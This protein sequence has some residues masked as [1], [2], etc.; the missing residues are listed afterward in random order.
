MAGKSLFYLLSKL[1]KDVL[2]E[3]IQSK[4][5][6]GSFCDRG[7][8][9][10]LCVMIFVL[11]ASIALL[12]SFAA[13]AIC[14][15]FLKK[16]HCVVIEWP[17]RTPCLNLLGKIHFIWQ[18]FAPPVNFL[19]RPLQFLTL[20][21][22]ISVLFSQY[23]TL[24]LFAF[25]GKFIKCVFL[26]FSFI[27]AFSD[28][29][30][31]RIF[32]KF[33]L[34]SAFITALNGIIQHYT[35][36][37]YLN[38]HFISV[39]RV[40][41]F[42]NTA[43]GLGAYLLPVIGIVTHFLYSAIVRKKSWVLGGVLAICLV[44]LLACL[45]W[46]YSRS[47]WVGYLVILFVMVLFDRRKM[48]FL[49]VLL[50]VFIFMFL[51]S[52]S[53][54]RHLHLI[55][56]N[57]GMGIQKKDLFQDIESILKQ[58]PVHDVKFILEEGGSGRFNFWMNAAS[59]IR[60]S[61]VWGSGLN[62]Y[63][64]IIKRNP[65]QKT[66]WYAHN[67][68]LQM[69]AEIGLVGL[70]CFLWMLFVL[71]WHGLNYCKQIKDLWPLTFLQGALSGLFGLLVQSFFDNTFYTVQLS[72]LMWVIFGLMVAVTRLNSKVDEQEV[73]D[74]SAEFY[75]NRGITSVDQDNFTQ[76]IADF[77][78]AIE[79]NPNVAEPYCA[80]AVAYD[81]KGKF[82]QA[83]TDFTKAIE[84]NPKDIKAYYTRG[85][86]YVKKGKFTQALSDFTKAIAIN[87]DQAEPYC[88]RGAIYGKQRKFTQSLSDFTKAIEI[89]PN[90]A[91]A[92]NL[93]AFLYYQ[94]KEYDKAWAGI[95][96]AEELGGTPNP[97]FIKSLKKKTG[98]D[99]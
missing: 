79:I 9:F 98:K 71:L 87:P 74:T 26:Y 42:F 16:I 23:P 73:P 28:E 72:M 10:S 45:C 52:L 50:L 12:D 67:S 68:Y 41:S 5:S 25:F 34:A 32:L 81:I 94:L 49:G 24:S 37:N 3:L 69:A 84:I 86:I 36:F 76:S 30:R 27:E 51:P 97:R 59:I 99:K 82:N 90:Y 46:S 62:T 63:T 80:R 93:R 22:F 21:V 55:N 47:A 8:I 61:P 11:P 31:I 78:K 70:A 13:L 89:N 33:F 56:D 88:A 92:Y 4:D 65:D 6:V 18:G 40:N 15:Y 17:S 66:W 43:N 1:T 58:G 83:I 53:N 44:I 85:V 57:S 19:N 35:G 29:K 95:H 77:T 91:D 39:D 14:F 2:T 48:L 64:R 38:W 96:K 7:I 60:S 75:F 20:A 54:V